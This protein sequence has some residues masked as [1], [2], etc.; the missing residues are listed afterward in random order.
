MYHFQD[1]AD[2]PL[3]QNKSPPL[4]NKARVHRETSLLASHKAQ[5]QETTMETTCL[6]RH[7]DPTGPKLSAPPGSPI[8]GDCGWAHVGPKGR[9]SLAG[10]RLWLTN[11]QL[12]EKEARIEFIVQG[13]SMIVEAQTQEGRVQSCC[14]G[15]WWW[16]EKFHGEGG[17]GEA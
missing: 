13:N 6:C 16:A 15:R 14:R 9:A 3:L 4:R 2:K 1:S 7:R 10:G 5:Q 11:P 8:G 17:D 12:L